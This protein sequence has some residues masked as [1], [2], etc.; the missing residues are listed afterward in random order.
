M[1][2]GRKSGACPSSRRLPA[3]ETRE[4]KALLSPSCRRSR[5]SA[6]RAGAHRLRRKPRVTAQLSVPVDRVLLDIR[7][8]T[9]QNQPMCFRS[10]ISEGVQWDELPST[11]ASVPTISPA[12]Q[13]RDLRA[14]AKRAGHHIVGVFKETA[15][16]ESA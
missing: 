9:V 8:A 3:Y 12:R 13:E 5:S 10:S 2:R 6:T 15:S 7:G 16:G 4:A 14:F 1:P 11:A